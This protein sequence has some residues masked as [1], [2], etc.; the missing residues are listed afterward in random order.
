MAGF[1]LYSRKAKI[2]AMGC[3]R[4]PEDMEDGLKERFPFD[5]GFY[6]SH[7]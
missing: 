4:M 5:S 6:K 7:W 1:K 2:L 3:F